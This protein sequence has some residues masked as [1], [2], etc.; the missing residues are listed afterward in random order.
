MTQRLAFRFSPVLAD[1]DIRQTLA[2]TARGTF[3]PLP[4]SG[5]PASARYSIYSIFSLYLYKSRHSDGGR[6]W[7]VYRHR[8]GFHVSTVTASARRPASAQPRSAHPLGTQ[9][10]RFTSTKVHILA[11]MW[12]GRLD[13]DCRSSP[14]PAASLDAHRPLGAQFTRFKALLRVYSGSIK[15][16]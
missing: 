1:R 6:R 8:G 9:F 4:A 2:T 11:H 14:R 12:L 5:R 16:P 13:R 15:A 7:F 10:T 3:S